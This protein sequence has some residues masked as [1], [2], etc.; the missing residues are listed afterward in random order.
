MTGTASSEN[1][2]E[3]EKMLTQSASASVGDDG[4]LISG[5]YLLTSY[6]QNYPEYLTAIGI[7]SFVVNMFIL[8]LAMYGVRYMGYSYINC[9]WFAFP[10]EALEVFTLFLLRVAIA[11]YIKVN[12]PEGTLA[13]LN[14]M[15]GG[16]HFGFGKGVGGLLG[17]ILKD[18]LGSMA[19]AFR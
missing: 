12:A 19:M 7:P 9:P 6:D 14:G 3:T 18:Q 16:A 17:G 11:Q 13:T 15:A 8:G 10:F 2:E 4:D 1:A 5:E